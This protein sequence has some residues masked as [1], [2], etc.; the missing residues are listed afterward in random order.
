[1]FK[2]KTIYIQKRLALATKSNWIFKCRANPSNVHVV[3]DRDLVKFRIEKRANTFLACVQAYWKLC[4]IWSLTLITRNL[5]VVG[6]VFLWRN[7]VQRNTFSSHSDHEQ[8]MFKEIYSLWLRTNIVQR[9]SLWL[10]A[11][12]IQRNIKE[13]LFFWSSVSNTLILDF[14]WRF[15]VKAEFQMILYPGASGLEAGMSWG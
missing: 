7:D 13:V 2:R 9:Q 10:W 1:M 3:S 5:R 6:D 12:K 14:Y 11:N 4:T 15:S 8:I